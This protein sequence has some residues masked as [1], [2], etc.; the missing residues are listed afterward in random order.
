MQLNQRPTI[1]PLQPKKPKVDQTNKIPQFHSPL[2]IT[3]Q[4]RGKTKPEN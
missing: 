3:E 1:Q 4:I 2:R